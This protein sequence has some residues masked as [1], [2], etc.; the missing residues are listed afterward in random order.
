MKQLIY[1]FL[2]IST[3]TYANED[4]SYINLSAKEQAFLRN[5][6]VKVITSN[7]WAP[8][9]MSNEKDEL[10]G[11]CIDFWNLLKKRIGLETQT[12]VLQDWLEVLNNIKTKNAD[13]TLGTAY[14]KEKLDYANFT[15]SYI[16]FPIAF[17]TLYDKRFIPDASF[18][19]GKKVA[20][21]ENYS[22]HTIIKN[23][24]PKIHF[25][26]V[27]NTQEALK[28]LSAGKVA[29]AMDILPVIAHLISKNG[30]YN[31]KI[32]GTSKHQVSVSFMIRKDYPELLS[33]MNKHIAQL[34]P[35]DKNNIIR[36]WLTV[37]FDKQL[38]DYEYI[39]QIALFIL[40]LLLFYIFKQKDLK[41]YN[42]E[43]QKLSTTDTLT[44][45]HNRR[46]IDEILN[47]MKN[48]KFSIILLDIDHFK[49]INDLYGHL[50]GDKILSEFSK[51]LKENINQND[52]I[53][54]WGGEEFLIICKNT[55]ENEAFL[56]AQR[57]RELIESHDFLIRKVTASF[58]ICEATKDLDIK[59]I[60]S[61]A[62]NALYKAKQQGRNQVVSSTTL[63]N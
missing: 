59:N 39:I 26:P 31:L 54:R 47:S 37:K 29:A 42:K 5:T 50:E 6:N 34:S 45:L 9:N 19:E 27:K 18:L 28:L 14:D 24:Y 10:T 8:L 61:N 12:V 23:K 40:L 32:S 17:A 20:V 41:K 51:I 60:L 57:L 7:T 52:E 44:K 15:S 1:I 38:V 33:I 63:I 13:I 53:A 35:E 36:N 22:S 30:Y 49:E 4:Y 55:S 25:V 46:K 2:I 11:I 43:L 3:I 21:G 48:K 16:S 56:I 58:G 62:D